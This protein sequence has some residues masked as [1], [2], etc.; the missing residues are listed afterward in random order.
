VKPV[1]KSCNVTDLITETIQVL[2]PSAILKKIRIDFRDPGPVIM[3]ADP[4]M[5]LTIFRNLLTNAVKFTQPEGNIQIKLN[6]A[7]K[8]IFVTVTDHGVGM[9]QDELGKLFRLDEN[10]KSKGTS[11]ETGSGF[12]LILC[13]EYINLHKGT[14]TVTSEKGKGSEFTVMLPVI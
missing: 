2:E 6:L 5:L 7:D 9:S 12:G 13:R 14:L 11:G 3:N 1:M 4:D 10:Y 8:E